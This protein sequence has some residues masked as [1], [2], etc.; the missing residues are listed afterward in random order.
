MQMSWFRENPIKLSQSINKIDSDQII[1]TVLFTKEKQKSTS[2]SLPVVCFPV[3]VQQQ[4]DK[5][6]PVLRVLVCPSF[7]Q[8]SRIH[9]LLLE[10][11]QQRCHKTLVL[12]ENIRQ[13]TVY[14]LFFTVI[15]FPCTL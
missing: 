5:S 10:A 11:V 1:I 4:L 9:L 14:L 3:H 15:G 8:I 12:F 6:P 2:I 13:Y 7:Y